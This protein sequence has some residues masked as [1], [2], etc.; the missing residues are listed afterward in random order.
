MQG[1]QASPDPIDGYVVKGSFANGGTTTR[2]S[3]NIRLKNPARLDCA[4]K[5]SWDNQRAMPQYMTRFSSWVAY[6]LESDFNQL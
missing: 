3:W 6:G 2:S 4:G 5:S 1:R